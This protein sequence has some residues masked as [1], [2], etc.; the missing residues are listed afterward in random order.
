MTKRVFSKG[1]SLK[2]WAVL[3]LLFFLVFFPVLLSFR[4]LTPKLFFTDECRNELT[5]LSKELL[6]RSESDKLGLRRKFGETTIVYGSGVSEDL[7]DNVNDALSRRRLRYVYVNRE[8][9]TVAWRSPFIQT[10]VWYIYG[11]NGLS[12]EDLPPS[13]RSVERLT[14][15]WFFFMR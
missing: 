7:L 14:P 9:G 13:V 15:D 10:G 5:N 8:R 3:V 2:G 11:E 6:S 12:E 4:Q 1:K